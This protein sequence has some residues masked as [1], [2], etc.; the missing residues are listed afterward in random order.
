MAG[1]V[2]LTLGLA[3]L[4]LTQAK[5]VFTAN[6]SLMIED[7]SSPLLPRQDFRQNDQ[8]LGT[9]IEIIKSRPVIEQALKSYTPLGL[10]P[11]DPVASL[12]NSL[13]ATAAEGTSVVKL[14]FRGLSSD[15]SIKA[16]SAIVKSY[17]QNLQQLE[18]ESYL[19][20]L[21]FLTKRE[22][23][24]RLELEAKE[25]AYREVREQ[26]PLISLGDEVARA[27]QEILTDLGKQLA[28]IKNRRVDF[29][30]QMLAWFPN[31]EN[32]GELV[33]SSGTPGE[34]AQ[35]R[36][37]TVFKPSLDGKPSYNSV[38]SLKPVAEILNNTELS[39]LNDELIAAESRE[40]DLISRFG[41]KYSEV[42]AV[43]AQIKDAKQKREAIID[44]L[45]GWLS[46]ELDAMRRHERSLTEEYQ[47]QFRK[48]KASEVHSVKEQQSADQVERSLSLYVT[49][50]NQLRE[51]QVD[52]N[53]INRQALQVVEIEPPHNSGQPSWPQ[54]KLILAL[55]LLVGIGSGGGLIA[56]LESWRSTQ[57]HQQRE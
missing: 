23:E 35:A 38:L 9:Q 54:K 3:V 33:E 15:D 49:A 25:A 48:I 16:L 42:V 51:W 40:K 8:L 36:R 18:K 27:D 12:R 46:R 37:Q 17:Q 47:K 57:S 43:R 11:L 29:E 53:S 45:P 56:I 7:A 34:D 28:E 10:D 26:S 52:E 2:A 39:K 1:C 22:A 30:N 50:V 20:T 41:E 21:Q 31:M 24:L 4:Y 13:Q 44:Q 6:A 5:E 19:D 14:A 55:A 32:W